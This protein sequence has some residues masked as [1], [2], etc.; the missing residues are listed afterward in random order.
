MKIVKNYIITKGSIYDQW[1][2]IVEPYRFDINLP[3]HYW[4]QAHNETFMSIDYN[5]V[6]NKCKKIPEEKAL[7]VGCVSMHLG[8]FLLESL[9]KFI[10]IYHLPN[11]IPVI[12]DIAPG[13]LPPGIKHL[14]M[15]DVEWVLRS[16]IKNEFYELPTLKKNEDDKK[17]NDLDYYGN[18]L[19][20]PEKYIQLSSWCEKPYMFA[21]IL[22]VI[23]DKAR[24]ISTVKPCDKI[25]LSR[26][27][28]TSILKFFKANDPTSRIYDQIALVSYAKELR[29][30]IGSNTHLSMFASADCKCTWTQNRKN[31]EGTKNQ[32]LCDMIKS[33]NI[34]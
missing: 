33:F 8:H 3:S 2:G 7:Y 20:I 30:D 27:E 9:Q 29:G 24:E 1:G 28:T 5:K 26:Y 34:F 13:F 4:Q 32:A 15:E 31:S 22:K 21:D 23:V 11:T 25:F 10:D 19:Y 17:E 12:V 6:K 16:F 14:P 18:T